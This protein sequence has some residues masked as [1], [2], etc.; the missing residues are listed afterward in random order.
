LKKIDKRSLIES[1]TDTFIGLTINF[2]LS[3]LVVY[4]VLLFSNDAFIISLWT[5]GVLT[6][7]AIIRRYLTRV[8]FK[9]NETPK[10]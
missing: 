8:Y 7:T 2:P 10:T 3:W 4:L 5:T 1:M 9:N 6:V